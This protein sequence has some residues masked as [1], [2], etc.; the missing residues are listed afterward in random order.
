MEVSFTSIQDERI[1]AKFI[2]SSETTKILYEIK[3]TMVVKTVAGWE[4]KRT[5][6]ER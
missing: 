1:G 6:L 4:L 3:Q 2:L 5:M